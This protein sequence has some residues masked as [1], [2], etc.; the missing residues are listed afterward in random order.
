MRAIFS[1]QI[2]AVICASAS[3]MFATECLFADV[4][5][6]EPRGRCYDRSGEERGAVWFA[7]LQTISGRIQAVQVEEMCM[8]DREVLELTI[9]SESEEYLVH[10]APMAFLNS[11]KFRFAIGDDLRVTGLV[12]DVGNEKVIIASAIERNGQKLALRD[13]AGR[14]AWSKGPEKMHA[15]EKES[16]SRADTH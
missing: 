15:P 8:N 5:N 10:V 3:L 6:G 4:E 1:K 13:V 9:K 12:R 2:G 14:P 16:P 7:P 11:K